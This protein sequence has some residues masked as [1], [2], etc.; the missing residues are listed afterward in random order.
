VSLHTGAAAPPDQWSFLSTV[1]LVK[2]LLSLPGHHVEEAEGSSPGPLSA[3][4]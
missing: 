1:T 2:A 3:D 4:A